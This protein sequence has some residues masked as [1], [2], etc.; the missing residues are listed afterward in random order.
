MTKEYT[1]DVRR[2]YVVVCCCSEDEDDKEDFGK[3]GLSPTLS[4]ASGFFML[5]APEAVS[6]CSI[7]TFHGSNHICQASQANWWIEGLTDRPIDLLNP[8][9]NPFDKLHPVSS[10]KGWRHRNWPWKRGTWCCSM[11]ETAFDLHLAVSQ[12]NPSQNVEQLDPGSSATCLWPPP[13]SGSLLECWTQC[14]DVQC[15]CIWLH[16]VAK[17]T[18]VISIVLVF[19]E[20]K[21]SNSCLAQKTKR[22]WGLVLYDCGYPRAHRFWIGLR[23]QLKDP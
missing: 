9:S 2:L 13:S 7:Y 10:G 1:V 19:F 5:V 14:S 21:Q 18:T 23:G 15:V 12:M 6:W 17:S 22:M 4:A 8:N 3:F 20:A 11:E 16:F